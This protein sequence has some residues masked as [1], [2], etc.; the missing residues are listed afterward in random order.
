MFYNV[1]YPY[2]ENILDYSRWYTIANI[3]FL[4]FDNDLGVNVT[5]DVV[6]YSLH[7]MAYVPAK[8]EVATSN[9]LEGRCIYNKIHYLNFDLDLG[10]NVS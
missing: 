7:N 8:F 1:H 4:T 9:D 10:V 5:R 6:Q 2:F 3:R